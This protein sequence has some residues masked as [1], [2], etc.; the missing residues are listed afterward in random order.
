MPTNALKPGTAPGL[1]DFLCFAVYSA[2]HAFNR[3]YKPLLDK[4]DLTYP[5]FLVMV[6]LW[7]EDDQTVGALG[8]KLFLESSTLT[9]LLKRLEG[10]GYV[11]RRRDAA[12]ERHVRVRLTKAGAALR[13]KARD[14]PACILEATGLSLE[15][16]R[17]LQ[18]EI[19][20]LRDNLRKAAG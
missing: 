2:G 3:V 18:G 11:T 7:G 8:D 1:D 12:D 5:Q 15:G 17:R 10:M 19:A 16:L 13:N 6:A 4:L 20:G 14:I 9:P